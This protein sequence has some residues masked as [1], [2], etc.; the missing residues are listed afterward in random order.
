MNPETPTAAV[1]AAAADEGLPGRLCLA[2]DLGRVDRADVDAEL[3]Q[4]LVVGAHEATNQRIG[5]E[6]GVVLGEAG[7]GVLEGVIKQVARDFARAAGNR[8][9][10]RLLLVVRHATGLDRRAINDVEVT[11]L[12]AE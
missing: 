8:F 5:T 10:Q 7:E 3:A 9:L 11:L 2:L 4:R 6:V 1:C 12:V